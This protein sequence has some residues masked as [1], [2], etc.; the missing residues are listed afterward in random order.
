MLGAPSR[1]RSVPAVP[2]KARLK[3]LFDFYLIMSLHPIAH[4]GHPAHGA[5]LKPYTKEDSE[6]LFETGS[7]FVLS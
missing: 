5:K 6:V 1:S 4:F 3:F 7:Q 2:V